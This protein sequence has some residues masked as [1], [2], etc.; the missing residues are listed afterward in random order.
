MQKFTLSLA[1]I[2]ISQ[3]LFCQTDISQISFVSYWSK[4]D[5]F[6]FEI[7]K[8]RTQW[9]ADTLAKNDTSRYIANFLVVDSTDKSYTIKWS[10]KTNLKYTYKLPDDI[11]LNLSKYEITEVLYQTSELGEFIGII[12]WKEIGAKTRS[13]LTDMF[14]ALGLDEN[15]TTVRIEPFI[16]LLSTK[17]GVE[18]YIFPELRYLHFP[19]GASFSVE[20]TIEYE[21]NYPNLLGGDPVRGKGILFIESVDFE[22]DHCVMRQQVRLNSEDTKK[23]ISQLLFKMGI[24]DKEFE[25]EMKRAEY[26]IISNN[27][28][29]FFYYPGI[30]ID[31]DAIR[32]SIIDIGSESGKRI[33]EVHITL[34]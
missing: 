30:P 8:M 16:S 10:C 27:R 5:S 17:E 14:S 34:Y 1:I 4:G 21:E 3:I 2:F 11:A 23:M 22:N 25:K 32:E 15:E 18:T 31:I 28:F 26:D 6:D 7:V 24:T 29:E 13:M 12:N 19:S 33:D 20:D 9:K